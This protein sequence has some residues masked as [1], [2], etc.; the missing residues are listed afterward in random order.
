MQY[1][2]YLFINLDRNLERSFIQTSLDSQKVN[3]FGDLSF[4]GN[5]LGLYVKGN[6]EKL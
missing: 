4:G 6:L 5:N 2:M 1:S 3:L